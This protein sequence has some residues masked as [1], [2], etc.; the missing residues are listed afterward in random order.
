MCTVTVVPFAGHG[1][2]MMCNRDERW[3]RPIASV[4]AVERAGR[5]DAIFPRDPLHGGTWIGANSAGLAVAV[6]NRYDDEP[7]VD[8]IPA[9]HSRGAIAV[10]LL[11]C[12]RLDEVVESM[13]GLAAAH[14][15]PFRLVALHNARAVIVSSN[16]RAIDVVTRSLASPLVLTSSA[17]GDARVEPLRRAL[18]EDLVGCRP[19]QWLSGQSQ[20]HRHQWPD[21]PEVSVLMARQ[22]AGTVSRSTIDVSARGVRFHYE[23][24]LVIADARAA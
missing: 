7:R 11:R 24:L 16:G 6:L 12:G 15:A 1:F 9:L 2:R 5:L 22:D 8:G 13:H 19:E 18:F 23:P 14:Y 3:S 4:P 10:E 20:F 21:R 17:L